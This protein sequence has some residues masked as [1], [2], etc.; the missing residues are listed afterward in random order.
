MVCNIAI[1]AGKLVFAP[2]KRFAGQLSTGPSVLFGFGGVPRLMRSAC[3]KVRWVFSDRPVC[4]MDRKNYTEKL[5]VLFKFR[6]IWVRV[7]VLAISVAC[8]RVYCGIHRPLDAVGAFRGRFGGDFC[9]GSTARA[10]GWDPGGKLYG[11]P[12]PFMKCL[13]EK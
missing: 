10:E 9:P 5:R 3:L 4:F 2:K 7:L 13:S 12:W 8:S 11:S 6:V 1:I